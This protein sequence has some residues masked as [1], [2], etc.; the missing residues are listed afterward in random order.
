MYIEYFMESASEHTLFTHEYVVDV[1]EIKW[2]QRT[3]EISDLKKKKKNSAQLPFKAIS[4]TFIILSVFYFKSFQTAKMIKYAAVHREMTK[5]F[6]CC[7]PDSLQFFSL[8]KK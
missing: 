6:C 5:K 1:S 2:A 4:M 8:N 7:L 3:S